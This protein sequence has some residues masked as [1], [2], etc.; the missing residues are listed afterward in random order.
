MAF[1]LSHCDNR[2]Q[3]AYEPN[4][5]YFFRGGGDKQSNKQTNII[6]FDKLKKMSSKQKKKGFDGWVSNIPIIIIRLLLLLLFILT[7]WMNLD[8]HAFSKWN[9]L[10]LILRYSKKQ[11][12]KKICWFI[13]QSI[14]E[15]NQKLN[16]HHQQITDVLVFCFLGKHYSLI[17]KGKH[18]F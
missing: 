9:S 11:Q 5:F 15:I 10:L 18:L 3:V 12:K 7:I 1:E 17:F 8:F 2:L 4:L 16:W 14:I 6:Y 13:N